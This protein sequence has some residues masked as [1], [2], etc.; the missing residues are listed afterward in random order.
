MALCRAGVGDGSTASLVTYVAS[1]PLSAQAARK[2]LGGCRPK[3]STLRAGENS[4]HNVLQ[5]HEQ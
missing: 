1:V 3:V 5:P 2:R 4:R